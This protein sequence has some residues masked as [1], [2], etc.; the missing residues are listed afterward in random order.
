MS[1]VTCVDRLVSPGTATLGRVVAEGSGIKKKKKKKKKIELMKFSFKPVR[2]NCVQGFQG[3][4]GDSQGTDVVPHFFF[5]F[6]MCNRLPEMVKNGDAGIFPVYYS[7]NTKLNVI[8]GED[9]SQ[10]PRL[11]DQVSP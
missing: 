4:F 7:L 10:I 3:P 11:A 9:G 1:V 5:F 6:Q 8:T 2:A